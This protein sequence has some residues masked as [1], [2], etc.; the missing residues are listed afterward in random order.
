[1]PSIATGITIAINKSAANTSMRVKA[2]RLWR[3]RLVRTGGANFITEPIGSLHH[4]EGV[5]V[6]RALT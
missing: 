6:T 4:F 1:M 5:F 3:V 2:R